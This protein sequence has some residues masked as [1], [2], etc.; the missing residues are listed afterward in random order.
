VARASAPKWEPGLE[1]AEREPLFRA[2]W[3]VLA[4]VGLLLAAFAMQSSIGTD[5][6][7]E[8]LGFSAAALAQG[9]LAPLILALFLHGSWAHVLVNSAF[10]VAFG[11]PVARR[12]GTDGRGALSF[13]GFFLVCGVL[14]NLSYAAVH[15]TSAAVVVGASGAASGLMAAAARLMTR[16]PGLAP[17]LSPPVI[18]MGAAWLG[19]NLMLAV[20][21]SMGLWGLSPGSGGAPVAWEAH[22]AGFAVGL[23]LFWPALRLVRRA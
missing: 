7:A 9:R 2:P 4:L 5:P 1:Q 3:P 22:I 20:L 18:S 6:V 10:I 17:L 16:G 8:G 23:L 12:F 13:F 14:S 15:P 11:S 21:G 19:V